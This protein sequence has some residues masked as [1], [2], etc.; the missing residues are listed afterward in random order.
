MGTEA[1]L[2]RFSVALEKAVETGAMESASMSSEDMITNLMCSD[3]FGHAVMRYG[4]ALESQQQIMRTFSQEEVKLAAE[5]MLGFVAHYGSSESPP[6]A[7]VI[8]CQPTRTFNESTGEAMDVPAVTEEALQQLLRNVPDKDLKDAMNPVDIPDALCPEEKLQVLLGSNYVDNMRAYLATARHVDGET[9][10]VQLRLPNGSRV[11]YVHTKNSPQGSMKLLF[12]G[13]RSAERP[14]A[15]GAVTLGTCTLE[16]SGTV[17]DFSNQ[18]IEMFAVTTGLC[19]MIECDSEHVHVDCAYPVSDKDGMDANL[20][21]MHLLLREP[22]WDEATFERAKQACKV[23]GQEVLGSL[24]LATEE[25]FFSVMYPGDTRMLQPSAEALA[26]MSLDTARAGIE[27]QVFDRLDHMEIIVAQDFDMLGKALAPR[28]KAQRLCMEEGDSS[29][30]EEAAKLRQRAQEALEE[31]LWRFLG[32]VASKQEKADAEPPLLRPFESAYAQGCGAGS[33]LLNQQTRHR[34]IHLCD[35]DKRA[36][37]IV[38]GGAPNCWGVFGEGHAEFAESSNFRWDFDKRRPELTTH[39]A[40]PFLCLLMLK[41]VLSCRL[42]GTLRE[43]MGL[44]YSVTFELSSFSLV[45]GGWFQARV[46]SQ[47]DKINEALEA[48]KRVIT[49]VARKPIN[50]LEVASSRQHLQRK[51]QNDMHSNDY[52]LSL[53]SNLQSDASNKDITCIRDI[54]ALL[55]KLG[56]AD[57]Q[58]AWRSLLTSEDQL[59]TAVGTQGPNSN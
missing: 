36:Y 30:E 41:D 35:P 18:Q 57:V 53:L 55:Q 54:E 17:A 44:A 11:S 16:E 29:V 24:E 25:A 47:P 9:G 14:D 56:P 20:Q 7:A 32:S 40:Y 13:G 23:K 15:V 5:W 50:T 31:G 12:P 48:A 10:I 39:R 58:N 59:F 37:A 19:V 51:H 4:D 26:D 45:Q 34:H 42:N 6:A 1:E 46:S 3:T 27:R 28:A 2:Q 21:L 8:L 22:R 43:R 38:G 49:E 33:G 52:W